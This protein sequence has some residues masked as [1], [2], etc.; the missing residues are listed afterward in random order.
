M[1]VHRSSHKDG[2]SL[3]FCTAFCPDTMIWLFNKKYSFMLH[4]R[5][6]VGLIALTSAD[7]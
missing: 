3:A 6:K 1:T 2:K 7:T 5:S 4:C